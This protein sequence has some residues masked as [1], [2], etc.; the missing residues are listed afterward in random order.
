M[1]WYALFNVML[2]ACEQKLLTSYVILDA[3]C[4]IEYCYSLKEY[5]VKRKQI[6]ALHHWLSDTVIHRRPVV[7]AVECRM[8]SYAEIVTYHDVIVNS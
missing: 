8:A 6:E 7:S 2:N 1:I 5:M 4:W 3:G